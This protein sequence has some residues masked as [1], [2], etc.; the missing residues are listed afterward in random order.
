[1]YP[2]CVGNI[3]IYTS[4]W[5]GPYDKIS[6]L[7]ALKQMAQTGVDTHIDLPNSTYS[8]NIYIYIYIYIYMPQCKIT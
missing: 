1:M 7:A 5:S 6:G 3:S 2:V 8:V 4:L